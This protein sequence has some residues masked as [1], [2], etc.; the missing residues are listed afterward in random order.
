MFTFLDRNKIEEIEKQIIREYSAKTETAYT[1]PYKFTE[2]KRLKWSKYSVKTDA[3]VVNGI[4]YPIDVFSGY[5][6]NVDNSPVLFLMPEYE[7]LGS[8]F[9]KSDGEYI[10]GIKCP[11]KETLDVFD[12]VEELEFEIDTKNGTY[13]EVKS[14]PL[15]ENRPQRGE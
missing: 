6:K 8:C 7:S 10:F 15:V 4:P 3:V 9:G 12:F 11:G 14:K 2:P 1:L 5:G 13:R